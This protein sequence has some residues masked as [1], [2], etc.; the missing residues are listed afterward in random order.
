MQLF[1][2][3]DFRKCLNENG[4]SSFFGMSIPVEKEEMIP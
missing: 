4:F 3:S 2:A 1:P